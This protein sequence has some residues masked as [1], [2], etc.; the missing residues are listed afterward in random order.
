M[1]PAAVTVLDPSATCHACGRAL[2]PGSAVCPG[3][4]AANGEANRCPHC[5]AIA[6]VE[7]HAALG[8]RCLVCGG[9]RVALNVTGVVPSG[10]TLAALSVAAKRHSEH[11]MYSSA[12]LVLA[13]MGG[14]ALLIATLV[15]IAA[16]P[17]PLPTLAAYLGALV[18]AVAGALA[19]SRASK[20]R[21]LRA[22]AL[23]SAQIGAL[24]DVLAVTGVL[25]AARV[26]E[27]MQLSPE[28]AELLLAEASVA[29]LLGQA[30]APRVRVPAIAATQAGSPPLEETAELA[31]PGART[32]RGQT[33]I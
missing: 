16:A 29:S 30:P 12:G 2:P 33:E 3:C 24:S 22:A 20:A 26:A 5:K 7:P 15:V 17:G 14:L 13:A 8:F 4:G 28:R 19:L 11:V 10:P 9:P 31:T 32:T 18:P 6:D 1:P 23:N 21:R 25:D 27:I